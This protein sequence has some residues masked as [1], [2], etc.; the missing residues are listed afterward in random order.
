LQF[1]N[2]ARAAV[3]VGAASGVTIEDST[4]IGVRNGAWD[5]WYVAHS[6][7]RPQTR[8]LAIAISGGLFPPYLGVTSMDLQNEA[9][10]RS[11]AKSVSGPVVVRRN[12]IRDVGVGG[13]TVPEANEPIGI[14]TAATDCAVT[15]EGNHIEGLPLAGSSGILV[16][17]NLGRT[18]IA[19]NSIAGV[20]GNGVFGWSFLFPT[21]YAVTENTVRVPANGVGIGLQGASYIFDIAVPGKGAVVRS[22]VERN[23]ITLEKG[24]AGI[25]LLENHDGTL[26]G[27]NTLAG[28]ADYGIQIDDEKLPAKASGVRL[29]ENDL[30]GLKAGKSAVFVAPF[31]A[32]AVA[33][34]DVT[35]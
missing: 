28:D 26:L 12:T 19:S 24:A 32:K 13:F 22:T 3:M 9:S 7:V 34:T 15:I 14:V 8:A 16:I 18:T 27:W 23:R 29:I 10:L 35:R 2:A 5:E 11:M 20:N 30:R 21:S 1:E 25:Q 6:P 17:T 4:F 33:T 31:A